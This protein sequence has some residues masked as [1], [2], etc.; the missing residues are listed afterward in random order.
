MTSEQIKEWKS[1][2]LEQIWQRYDD[3]TD[4]LLARPQVLDVYAYDNY[5]LA[6]D[7]S[8]PVTLCTAFDL[9]A[10]LDSETRQAIIDHAA[11]T[12]VHY[13]PTVG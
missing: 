4:A 1:M 10:W 8:S 13:L 7:D 3:M 11:F 9:P 6:K 5:T 12:R 2:T